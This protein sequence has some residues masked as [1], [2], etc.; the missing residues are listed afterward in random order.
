M[1]SATERYAPGDASFDGGVRGIVEPPASFPVTALETLG[2]CPLRYFFRHVLRVRELE[3]EASAQET[4][5]REMGIAVHRVLELVYA[6]L[7]ADRFLYAEFDETTLG[8]EV[9]TRVGKAWDR[10]LGPV[11]RRH[12]GRLPLLWE[13][14]AAD[15][16]AALTA[17]VR[18]DLARLAAEGWTL[19]GLEERAAGEIDIG[20]GKSLRASARFDRRLEGPAGFLIGDYKSS[21]DL[22]RRGD[23]T[24]MLK[25]QA[26]QVPL[27]RLI[28]GDGV[29]VELLGVGPGYDFDRADA[30]RAGRRVEFDGFEPSAILAGFQ[31]TLR[32]LLGLALRGRFPLNP[33]DRCC[34]RCP[35]DQACRRSHP[36]T[37][38][39]EAN[40]PRTRAYY[41]LRGKSKTKRPLLDAGDEES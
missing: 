7:D 28:A 40:D 21:G 2:T 13:R 34:P 1:L 18:E 30:V 29:R 31:E 36:P 9:A 5:P 35:Y 14:T 33:D 3:E 25:G 10:A 17:F 24:R 12:L 6:G 15:W 22:S 4:A 8:Q 11:E 27:Y 38:E 23:V 19:A 16:K 20:S 39:R 32:V 41:A 26:L 37:V